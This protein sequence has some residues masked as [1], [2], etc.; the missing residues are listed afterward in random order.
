M[1]SSGTAL[2]K[3]IFLAAVAVGAVAFAV[4]GGEFGTTDLIRQRREKAKI[5]RSIDSLQRTVDSLRRYETAVMQ[6]PATQ[7]RLA[8]EVFGMVRGDKELLYRFTDS[9][10]AAKRP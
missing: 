10:A 5:G 3:R 1:A 2:I 9:A 7:E 4:E 6:D 8:R